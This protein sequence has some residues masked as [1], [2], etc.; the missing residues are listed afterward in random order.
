MSTAER[1]SPA[2]KRLAGILKDDWR[3]TAALIW[4]FAGRAGRKLKLGTMERRIMR[5]RPS[6][7]MWAKPS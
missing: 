6:L 4:P 5:A 3:D 2:A 7:P 1:L